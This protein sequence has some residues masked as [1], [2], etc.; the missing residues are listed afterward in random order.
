MK[1]FLICE[2][3]PV[4][5]TDTPPPPSEEGGAGESAQ[6][7][8][9]PALWGIRGKLGHQAGKFAY[10]APAPGGPRPDVILTFPTPPL[11]SLAGSFV[12]LLRGA[13]RKE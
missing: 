1:F 7:A 13:K 4:P 11:L 9:H 8:D 2:T 12:K 5:K 10:Y 3:N 6:R